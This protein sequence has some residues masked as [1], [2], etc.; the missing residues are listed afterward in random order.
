M[1]IISYHYKIE[2]VRYLLQL[3][4]CNGMFNVICDIMADLL[5]CKI[6]NLLQLISAMQ[7]KWFL[8]D[9]IISNH[10]GIKCLSN[11]LQLEPCNS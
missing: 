3:E 9:I 11:L 8:N 10:Y 5:I 2:C 1:L 6:K 7:R 4:P